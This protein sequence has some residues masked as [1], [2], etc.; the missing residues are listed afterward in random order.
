MISIDFIFRSRRALI[1]KPSRTALLGV[2][3]LLCMPVLAASIE[4]APTVDSSKLEIVTTALGMEELTQYSAN[5]NALG[6]TWAKYFG[7]EAS[8]FDVGNSKFA[9]HHSVSGDDVGGRVNLKLA[10]DVSTPLGDRSRLYSRVGMYMW[11]V[12]VNYNRASNRLDASHESNS[13]MIGV[14]AMYGEDWLRVGIELEQVNAV[15]Y[16]D[17]REQHRVL[18]NMYSKF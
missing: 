9:K 18:F 6:I 7:M 14:G 16:E 10:L 13:G 4:S 2:T 8:Y 15:S 5:R 3:A 17:P 1:G 11:D 12:D